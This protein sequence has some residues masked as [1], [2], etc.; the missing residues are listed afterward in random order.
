VAG[1]FICFL[2]GTV[3]FWYGASKQPG[4]NGIGFDPCEANGTTLMLAGLFFIGLA[5]F[6]HRLNLP[7]RAGAAELERLARGALGNQSAF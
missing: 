2:L 6:F 5:N 4:W 7:E 1:L 3:W